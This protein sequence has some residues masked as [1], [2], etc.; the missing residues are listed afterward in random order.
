MNMKELIEYMAKAL[1]DDPDQVMSE[2]RRILRPGGKLLFLEHG[3]APDADVARWQDRIEPVWKKIA[4]GCHLSR[5]IGAA[6]RGAG[7]DVEP[8]G[9]GYL[10]KAPRFAG[11]NEWGIARKAGL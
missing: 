2:M 1:V 8:M 4:G 6:L 5:P 3:R 10:P 11:W 7:F 9:Q